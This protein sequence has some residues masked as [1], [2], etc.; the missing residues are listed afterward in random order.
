M[1]RV[2][3]TG[4]GAV[5]PLGADLESTWRGLLEGRSGIGPI[6]RF[7][8]SKHSV[9]IAGEADA[10]DPSAWFD[11]PGVRKTGRFLQLALA[12][13]RMATAGAG[14]TVDP[15][16]AERVGVYVGSGIGG[17]GTLCDATLTLDREGPRRVSPFTIPKIIVNMAPGMISIET[18]AL[19]PNFAVVSA[20]A[21]GN[22]CIGEA[23]RAIRHGS[24]DVC[25]A[26]GVEAPLEPV[27]VAAFSRMRA[28][29]TRNDD[30]ARASR[31]FD[32]ERDG[33]VMGEGAGILVLEELEF[34]RRRGAPIVAELVGYGLTSDAFHITRPSPDGHGAVRCMEM[35]LRDGA[36]APTDVGYINAHGTATVFNDRVESGA[37]RRVFGDHA[38][39]LPVS[40]TKSATGHLLGAA[41]GLEAAIVALA[42]QRGVLPPTINLERPDPDCDLDHVAN[43][44]REVAA[45]V[46]LSNAF[47][48]G[49]TNACLAFR[50]YE[51]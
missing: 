32:A 43:E 22:H 39:R 50:R 34:A 49:G 24:L 13:A 1:R 20:C 4:L 27:A 6:T 17:I 21:T 8:A 15:S 28:L 18:G 45:D 35:T 23:L 41:G 10:F 33:F 38:D 3:V 29:S 14:L 31:P 2:V 48:F 19:G 47:G 9:R 12:S 46:A 16:W 51:G 30:P 37:I 42:L 5:S 7:D 36:L 40:S 25:I 11:G 44:A 26:G